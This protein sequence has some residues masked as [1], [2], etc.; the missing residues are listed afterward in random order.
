MTTHTLPDNGQQ[1]DLQQ[2]NE[3]LE[4]IT[5]TKQGDADAFTQ[6]IEKY[7]RPVYNL[8]YYML[9]NTAEAE[10]AAQEVFLRAFAKLDSYDEQRKFSSWLFSIAS[11]YC[12]DQLKRPRRSLTPLDDLL[13][14]YY[15]SSNPAAQPEAILL[16]N[17]TAMEVHRLL[18]ILPP[19]YRAA[20]ILKYW[21]AMSYQEIAQTLNTTVGVI[22]SNLFQARRK[23]AQAAGQPV[24][25]MM[26]QSVAMYSFG[27]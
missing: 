27:V 4:W 26:T 21:Q 19:H 20:V 10:D 8:C 22:K 23:M 18:D 25:P 9:R 3:D 5:N 17:E 14:E 13:P 1:A 15:L 24:K 6:I 16:S 7:Q 11:H 2:V 12:L